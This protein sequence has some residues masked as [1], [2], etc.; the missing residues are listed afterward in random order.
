MAAPVHVIGLDIGTTSTIAVLVELPD[1]VVAHASRPVTLSS[2][3]AGWAEEDPHEWWENSCAVLREI[4]ARVPDA[5]ASLAGICVTGMLPAVVLLDEAGE[6]LRPSIQQSD[7]RCGREVGELAA[8]VDESAFLARTGNGINQQLVAAKLRWLERHE[9]GVFSRIATVFGSYDYI[10]WRLTGVTAVEH[11]WAL[12]A[13][14][15]DL[16]DHRIA[17]DLVALGHIPRSALP[18]K[19]VTHETLGRV[20]AEAA[21][22]TG[23]PEGLPVFGGAADHIASAF[24]AGLVKPGEVLLKFGGAGDIIVVSDGARPDPRLFLDYHLIPG[25]YAPNGCM[26]TSGS[27]LNWMTRLLGPEAAAGESPHAVLDALAGGVPAGSEGVLALPYFLGEKTPIHDPLAAGTFTGL[28]LSHGKGHIWRALLEGIAYAFRHHLEVMRDIGHPATRLLASDGGSKSAVW[29]QIMA[30]VAGAPVQTLAD[31]YGSSVGAAWV[32]A[33][34]SGADVAWTDIE[35]LV[36]Y[37]TVYEPRPEAVAVYEKG[38]ADFRLLYETLKP[39][40]HRGAG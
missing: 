7:G 16:A 17:D 10:N 33:I 13:G 34:G 5:A 20:S 40:F 25:L 21:A 24:A 3:K 14:F 4:L 27:A 29:M 37:G 9:A 35:R 6:V 39:F 12:E 18:Q 2:P 22:A 26:A 28:S 36:S 31:F 38:Y 11:N 15:I 8:E 1:R 19:A 23:L 32:A 30:D